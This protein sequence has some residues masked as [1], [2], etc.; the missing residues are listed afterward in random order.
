MLPV[1]LI[2]TQRC[3]AGLHL[4]ASVTSD[5][6]DTF[7]ITMDRDTHDV[8]VETAMIGWKMVDPDSAGLVIERVPG[9]GGWDVEFGV[10]VLGWEVGA[11]GWGAGVGEDTNAGAGEKGG[12]VFW[13][14][15]I[16]SSSL[17]DWGFSLR[18]DAQ[19]RLAEA[20]DYFLANTL[21]CSVD[22]SVHWAVKHGDVCGTFHTG[23]I[24]STNK[25]A[26]LAWPIVVVRDILNHSAS[27]WIG[28]SI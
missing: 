21:T 1:R 7:A 18:Y 10:A 17:K 22:V 11:G 26:A 16:P 8:T 28:L 19:R 25:F 6:R 20:E 23:V 14:I 5:D 15:L 4:S 3:L 13:L 27:S 24:G 12:T 9:S 2:V